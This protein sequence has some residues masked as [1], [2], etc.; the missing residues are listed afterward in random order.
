MKDVILELKNVTKVIGNKT[1]IDNVDLKISEG[2]IFGFLGPNGAGKTTTIRMIVGLS[3]LTKGDIL[4]CGK[5]ISTERK[6][7]IKNIGAI[8]EN[9][10]LYK[11]MTGFQNLMYFA[12]LHSPKISKDRVAQIVKL[13]GLSNSIHDKVRTYS[14]GMKQRLGLAQCL[15]HKPKLL[16]LDEPTN[17]LDPAGIKEIRQY[18]KKLASETGMA[19]MVSSHLLSEMEMMCDKIAIL[20]NGK[21]I[22]TQYVNDIESTKNKVVF[23]LDNPQHARDILLNEYPHLEIECS[24][25][26][27]KLNITKE[28]IPPFIKLLSEKNHYIYGIKDKEQSL[29]DRYLALTENKEE[30]YVNSHSK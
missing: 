9:P 6:E 17:G 10:E 29:E 7:A 27:L 1:I 20:Q 18:L 23:E 24:I 12:R 4:I 15:L 26:T 16:I 2:E 25:N 28:E 11:F 8:I 3:S 14:L 19:I 5:S 21:V 30:E 22:S 13:V